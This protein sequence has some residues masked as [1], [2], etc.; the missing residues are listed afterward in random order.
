MEAWRPKEESPY[1]EG[2][3]TGGEEWGV[4][5][6]VVVC[7]LWDRAEGGSKVPLSIE[8]QNFLECGIGKVRDAKME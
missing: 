4:K 3:G 7:V 8:A 5:V 2:W 6:V 1:L